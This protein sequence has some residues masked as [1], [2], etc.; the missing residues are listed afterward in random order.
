MFDDVVKNEY[1]FYELKKKPSSE[2]LGDYYQNQY[3][4]MA[5]GSYE[6]EY[7][8]EE[9]EYF[10][11]KVGQNYEVLTK[12]IDISKIEKPSFIDI[13]CGE[14]WALN[15][16]KDKG[17]NITG[18]DFSSYGCSKFNN[19]C[20]TD[21]ITGNIY[22]SIDTL[23]KKNYKYNCIL[24]SN[25]LEHVLDPAGLLLSCSRLIDSKGILIIQVPNDFSEF[26]QF[27]YERD[28]ISRPYW[29]AIPDHVSYFN[30][31][32]LIT[33]C[34]KSG[35]VCEYY[36]ADYPIEVNLINE[37]TN[38]SRDSFR[39]KSCH[40]ARVVMENYIDKV[41]RTKT[42]EL[43]KILAEVGLGRQII[44]FFRSK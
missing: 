21:L 9:I 19:H 33:F 13:G 16:F 25:I 34:M 37:N 18:L 11:N 28:Y 39:G 1:G 31:N 20:C 43:Y 17:W 26:Q 10:F 15:F 5:K 14:G 22:E 12:L 2:E 35:W 42:T 38:Y 41:S 4:Q 24:L 36:M 32:T 8:K 29:V 30:L 3:Y 44:G 7:S 40:N 27:L 23:I 6:K